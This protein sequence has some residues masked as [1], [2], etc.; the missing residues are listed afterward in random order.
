MYFLCRVGVEPNIGF[1]LPPLRRHLCI[2]AFESDMS[3]PFVGKS[4]ALKIV[5][6]TANLRFL[7]FLNQYCLEFSTKI[8]IY[9]Q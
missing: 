9:M 1:G 6:S 3:M 4:S 5:E 2:I 8:D 7:D